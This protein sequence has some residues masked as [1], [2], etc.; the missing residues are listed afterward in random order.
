[1]HKSKSS[2]EMYG[3]LTFC[4]SLILFFYL[5]VGYYISWSISIVIFLL[6]MIFEYGKKFGFVESNKIN[7]NT[8]FDEVRYGV[9]LCVIQFSIFFIL[10]YYFNSSVILNAFEYIPLF[11]LLKSIF[12][13][14]DKKMDILTISLQ[15]LAER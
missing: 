3:V 2:I 8:N 4:I 1:M 15:K 6:V 12:L 13:F 9:I 10:L 14:V 7:K 11:F 5:E